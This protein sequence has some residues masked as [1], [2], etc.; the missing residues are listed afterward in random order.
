MKPRVL[1]L[2]LCCAELAFGGGDAEP[3]ILVTFADPGLSNASRPGPVR[4]GYRRHSASYLVSI[5]VRR[6]A[7]QVA[8][9]YNLRMVDE[10]PIVPL[11]VHCLVYAVASDGDIDKLLAELRARPEVESA[12]RMNEFNV[13]GSDPEVGAASYGELQYNLDTLELAQA[14]AWSL[15]AGASVTVIDTGADIDHP[16]LANQVKVHIDFVA[17][18]EREFVRDAHGTAVAGIIGAAAEER[19][20]IVGIAPDAQLTVL[21][22]CWYES[23]GAAAV[24]NSFTLAKAL[25]HALLS[26]ANVLNLSL[27]GPSDP[28]LARLLRLVVDRGVVVV[29]AELKDRSAGFPTN[30]PGVISV[31]PGAGRGAVVRPNTVAAPADEILVLAPGGGYDY[32]S[33]SSLAAAQ[34]SGIAALL[35]ARRP[36]LSAVDV[37]A[38]LLASRTGNREYVNAC[39]ALAEL[40]GLSGCEDD[41][42]VQILQPAF[43][44]E[45]SRNSYHP[46]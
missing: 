3:R 4:P 42:A 16:A 46:L 13:M 14:H 39:R 12:Q 26:P 27:G 38:L 8:R 28:L 17:E 2:L 34:V 5:D 43:R 40:L 41:A 44:L 11:K 20:G 32:A 1:L 10:W 30:V 7:D 6:A 19:H 31:G 23:Q 24:C 21:K 37:G 22:A 9:I 18:S 33:G 45:A 29:A 35:L 15:G 36:D 25:S